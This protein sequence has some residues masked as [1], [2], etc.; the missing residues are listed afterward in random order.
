ML[1]SQALCIPEY[2][3]LGRGSAKQFPDPKEFQSK[4]YLE[5]LQYQVF[6]LSCLMWYSSSG[7]FPSCCYDGT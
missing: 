4:K 1:A 6:Y 7:T 5:A 2:V 3:C